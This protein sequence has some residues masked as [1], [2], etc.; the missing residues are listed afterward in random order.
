MTSL[1]CQVKDIIEKLYC[2]CYNKGLQVIIDPIDKR[3]TL[4]L[5]IHDPNFGAFVLSNQCS[6]DKEFLDYVT[7]ELK[8]KKLNRSRHYKLIM[9]GDN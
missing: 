2:C 7:K 5:Y 1:E 6:S 9:Y 8:D 4:R 3:Y